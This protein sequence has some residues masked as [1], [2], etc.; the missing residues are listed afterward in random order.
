MIRPLVKLYLISE[1]SS[2]K[3]QV[4]WT[5]FLT[6]KN[7][8]W[9]WFLQ[10]TKAVKIQFV[11]LDFSKI[12]C[13]STGGKGLLMQDWVFRLGIWKKVQTK[14]KHSTYKVQ[15]KYKSYFEYKLIFTSST[16]MTDWCSFN[17]QNIFNT[18]FLQGFI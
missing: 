6:C 8:F 3:N 18:K 14:Y 11:E 5:G 17:Y 16:S 4:R 7:K 13:R 9:N 15:A 10:A 1:K 12:K 2:L